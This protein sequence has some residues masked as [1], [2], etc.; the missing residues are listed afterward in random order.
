[1]ELIE[2]IKKAGVV[3]AG[4]AGF[5]THVK[6]NAK[7]EYL[8]INAAEC[9]PLIET[10]KFLCREFADR[11]ID[12]ILLM[13]HHLEAQHIVIGLKAKYKAE[14]A[15]LEKAI[16]EKHAAVEIF[17][18]R[19]FYPAG[20]EQVLVQQVTG[21]S[22][23]ERGLPLNVGAVVENVGTVLSIADALEDKP[24]TEKYL[25]VTGA[26][27][28]PVMFKV[29]LGTPIRRIINQVDL[30]VKDYAVIIGGPMMGKMQ[31]SD[32]MIDHA[33]VTKTTGNLLILPKDH[34]L[35]RRAVKP[36]QTMIRQ[37]RTS[38]IQCRFCT[39]LCPREQIGHNVKPNQIMRNLWRQDQIT[40]VKEFEA[41]FG[42]AANC[43]SCGVC[44]MFAC[45]MGL[46]PRKMND[47]TKGLLRGLGI[48]PEKNQ[49]PTAKST[50]EQRRIPTERLIA[51][52]GL[53][54]YVFHVEPK[55]ITD[56]DVKE[57]I[58]ADTT[59]CVTNEGNTLVYSVMQGEVREDT[60]NVLTVPVGG[61]FRVILSDGTMVFL[62]SGSELRY[63][64]VFRDGQ[65]EVF[66]KGEAWFEVA[67]DSVRLFRVHAGEMD[68]RVLG[69][70]FN[71]KAYERME[72]IATTLVTGSVEITCDNESFRIVPGEQFEYRKGLKLAS[73][74]E[75]DTE[76]YTSWKDGY[77]KFRQA[78]LEEIMTTLSVWY[79]LEVFYQNEVDFLGFCIFDEAFNAGSVE[80]RT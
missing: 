22:V 69:T 51:R 32:S 5:P 36:V 20:D 70:S 2:A 7:A 17:P 40:D 63:P 58:V 3:G 66:L 75:V 13:G 39:D 28:E 53:S 14:I 30:R 45:P 19:T 4:G 76:L 8:I 64:E 34:Y 27:R 15:A 49:N 50:I 29:P 46:S 71:V 26:V 11:I 68:V 41:T 47:Y 77:Y 54:D 73:V 67:K 12:T 52:L 37:A 72:S 31:S 35:V 79:G 25:S 16:R 6:L 57:V 62:N 10:D 65:R 21:R 38:C 59:L 24:V 1:M 23:P 55:L 43:S 42:S 56:L 61:E 33:V 48:N 9:E 18:M 60:Y 44:E 74:R 78:S 80:I